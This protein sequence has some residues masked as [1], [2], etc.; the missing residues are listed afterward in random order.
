VYAMDVQTFVCTVWH[1]SCPVMPG[2][3]TRIKTKQSSNAIHPSFT[4]GGRGDLSSAQPD[5]R[6]LLR[7][8]AEVIRLWP[9]SS[10]L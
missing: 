10:T 4:K 8:S 6:A 1:Q 2:A 9:E 5:G 7:C 3:M